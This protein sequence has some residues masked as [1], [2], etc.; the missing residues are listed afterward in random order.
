M[1]T[2]NIKWQYAARND[3]DSAIICRS[4][5]LNSEKSF[6]DSLNG[7]S[8]TSSQ[9]TIK[10][11]SASDLNGFTE[12]SEQIYE[13]ASAVDGTTYYYCA[14]VKGPGNSPYKVGPTTA[15]ASS[16]EVTTSTASGTSSVAV[17]TT[18]AASGSPQ[19]LISLGS[20]TYYNTAGLETTK[21]EF[22]QI[23]PE[24]DSL[25]GETEVAV[26]LDDLAYALNWLPTIIKLPEGAVTH[27]LDFRLAANF[28]S[29]SQTL[30]TMQVFNPYSVSGN[31]SST[32]GDT[33]V[34][35]GV[36]TLNVPLLIEQ[37][38]KDTADPADINFYYHTIL[39]EIY[40]LLA[41]NEHLFTPEN[42]PSIIEDGEGTGYVYAGTQALVKYKEYVELYE[43]TLDTTGYDTEMVNIIG[44]PIENIDYADPDSGY[45][46]NMHW[47]EGETGELPRYRM[48]N[49]R[50]H[51]ALTH[52][53]ISGVKSTAFWSSNPN[54]YRSYQFTSSVTLGVL[55][56]VGYT[57]DWDAYD[58]YA[59]STVQLQ[60]FNPV[61]N[62]YS[63]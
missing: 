30:A 17:I 35:D 49:G 15:A 7:I 58:G 54:L 47:E 11:Y 46:F 6:E 20:T 8:N 38:T 25:T 12:N 23:Y 53:I 31:S 57:I 50:R 40:H 3:I 9:E 28:G 59:S 4:T 39:H 2:V 36:L 19:D 45:K 29:N 14:A 51:W 52:D 32:F 18:P 34:R 33:L 48:I 56:D 44:V 24:I 43:S 62:Y 10:T 22:E 63:S 42:N 16:G 21:E 55:E 37:N 41:F 27:N 13:D 1:P 5:S 61:N 26:M 60:A